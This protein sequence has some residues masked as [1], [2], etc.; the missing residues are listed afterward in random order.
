VRR[1]TNMDYR[2]VSPIR[3]SQ[4]YI[5]GYMFDNMSKALFSLRHTVRFTHPEAIQYLRSLPTRREGKHE[6]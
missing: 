4:W 3:S 5:D 2:L 6:R 1:K